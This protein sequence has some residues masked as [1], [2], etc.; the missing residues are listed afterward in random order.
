MRKLVNVSTV[1][2]TII[3]VV[4]L[5]LIFLVYPCRVFKTDI[6][7][8]TP[9]L[10]E[11]YTDVINYKHS[12]MQA[13][14]ADYD[15]INS[16]SLYVGE[17][18]GSEE[19]RV[20]LVDGNGIVLADEP[21][22]MTGIS[23]KAEFLMDV[24]LNVGEVYFVKFDTIKSLYLA[25]EPWQLD[26]GILAMSYYD[27]V[28]LEGQNIV[29]DYDY[30]Q[31]LDK[32]QSLLFIGIVVLVAAILL[33]LTGLIFKDPKKDR[34]ITVKKAI[35]YVFN[36]LIGL[37][38]VACQICICMGMVSTHLLDNIVATTAVVFL[39]IILFYVVNHD[40]EGDSFVNRDYIVDNIPHFIQSIGIMGAISACCEYV[41]GFYNIDHA[42]AER[43]EMLWFSLIII[44]MFSLKEIINW[45]NIAYLAVAAVAGAI[46]Y[47]SHILEEMSDADRFVVRGDILITILL[48]LIVIRTVIAFFKKKMS[49]ANPVFSLIVILYLAMIIIFRNERWWT[50]TLAVAFT[51][52]ILNLGF[53]DKKSEFIKNVIRGVILH[54]ILSTIW[55]LLY[56][57]F[58][59][60]SNVRFTHCF[61]TSTI[62]ATYM[63]MVMCVATV[64]LVS[65]IRTICMAEGEDGKSIIIRSPKINLLWKELLFFGVVVAYS[66]FTMARTA[67]FAIIV[68][69][70]FAMIL[71]LFGKGMP[72]VKLALKSIGLMIV[73]VILTF[74]VTFE[75][76]RTIP[77]LVSEPYV[78]D[79]DQF[80]DG[81]LRGSKLSDSSYL[82][83]GR[84][85]EIFASRVFGIDEGSINIYGTKDEEFNEYHAKVKDLIYRRYANNFNKYELSD[86]Q[87]EMRIDEDVE[88]YNMYTSGFS[89][90][91]EETIENAKNE[92]TYTGDDSD[93]YIPI[94]EY[95]RIW[96]EERKSTKPV[97]YTNGRIDI[98]KSYLEQLNMTGHE[99]M[100]AIL[101]DGSEATHAHDV[102][103]QVAYDHGIPTA[104]IFIIFGVSA[105]IISIGYYR[106]NRFTAPYKALSSVII[107]AFAVAGVVEWTYHL[108]HPMAFVLWLC[109]SPLIFS[110]SEQVSNENC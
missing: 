94:E 45:Y 27:D 102:Y 99:G 16:I 25:Q 110:K 7:K 71:L 72:Y 70:I 93:Y 31:P 47:N 9:R 2:K 48:G 10:T 41:S 39:G 105:L 81:V 38:L 49:K 60:Y 59:N 11:E 103:L 66:A 36:P 46:Y 44:S 64:V 84:F 106:K 104:V 35:Q 68:A 67:I 52:L 89:S 51:L 19:L 86:E 92:G 108:S 109:I 80:P 53:W 8:N 56:R 98:Y 20:K 26:S 74:V 23:G 22:D 65:K 101:S 58:D 82:E 13:F 30:I 107:V 43:K 29:M 32:V 4:S 79:I 12:A 63:T 73:A 14:V 50:V 1:I 76:Q 34:I 54:F 69:F 42:V 40:Y 87:L 6:V 15:H 3:I 95:E 24:D 21:K 55:V 88:L 96:A 91:I 62:T 83:V 5:L 90:Q 57:P 17:N 97:D 33:S 85:A 75:L 37:L 61:H 28:L 18:S 78:F 77:C 100:G